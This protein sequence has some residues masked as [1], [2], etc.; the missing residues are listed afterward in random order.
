[1]GKDFRA[2]SMSVW[3]LV[4]RRESAWREQASR[5]Q[6]G[7]K[8]GAR[9]GPQLAESQQGHKSKAG[10]QASLERT[11]TSGL[12]VSTFPSGVPMPLPS[13]RA[14]PAGWWEGGDRQP[15][16][17]ASWDL[18]R[19]RDRLHHSPLTVPTPAANLKGSSRP[20]PLALATSRLPSGC[21]CL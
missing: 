12:P 18:G 17:G 19:L 3:F 16:L 6:N 14:S 4:Q 8:V 13:A 11:L 21:L 9:A 20:G 1:M 10:I 2:W 15:H 5:T 7:A